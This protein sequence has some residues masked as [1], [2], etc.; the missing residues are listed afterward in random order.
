MGHTAFL[1]IDM[2]ND[3]CLPGAP[4]EVKG[5][6]EVAKKIREALQACRK[7]GLPV[8]HVFRYYRPNGSDVEITRYDKF[9]QVGGALIEGTKGGEIVD[10]LK[11]IDGEYLICKRR[12]SAFFQTEL[13]NLLKR[14]DVDQVVVTGVQ[15]PNCIR[16]TVWDANSL[17]YEVIVLT[18]GTGASTSEVHEANLNDMKNIGVKLMTVEE[19]IKSLP[20]P[21]KDD[22]VEKI[23][24]NVLKA[25]LES[26]A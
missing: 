23:R 9:V 6:M 15:T 20:N 7:Y 25:K 14:L 4:F 17:D 12:W 3:F 5:A 26:R 1:I 8:V 18:D 10:E 24:N 13:D 2:Q 19:F 16:G 22:L 21:P 11:P